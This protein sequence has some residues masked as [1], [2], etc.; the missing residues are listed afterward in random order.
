MRKYHFVEQHLLAELWLLEYDKY[1]WPVLGL[2][3]E[4]RH[5]HLSAQVAILTSKRLM[6]PFT[7]KCF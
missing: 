1:S 5:K 2:R 6:K 3:E 4:M 7:V